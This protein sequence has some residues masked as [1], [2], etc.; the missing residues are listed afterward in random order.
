MKEYYEAKINSREHDN[1]SLKKQLAEKETDLRNI[2]NK[3]H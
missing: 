1:E 2:I 3:Y